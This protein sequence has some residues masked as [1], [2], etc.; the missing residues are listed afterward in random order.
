MRTLPKTRETHGE[1]IMV[2]FCRGDLGEVH[3]L[4]NAIRSDAVPVGLLGC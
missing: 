1:I 3:R 4:L 2:P